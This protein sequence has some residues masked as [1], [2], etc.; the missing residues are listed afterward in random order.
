MLADVLT[1][2]A[3]RC[4]GRRN[5][6]VETTP[7]TLLRA[8]SASPHYVH[9]A[10]ENQAANP[11]LADHLCGGRA[12]TPSLRFRVEAAGDARGKTSEISRLRKVRQS[13]MIANFESSRF[14]SFY[15]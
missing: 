2:L 3:Y 13:A 14:E 12:E 5:R 10:L 1:R 8:L 11:N 7:S 9:T 4:H 6:I 15:F